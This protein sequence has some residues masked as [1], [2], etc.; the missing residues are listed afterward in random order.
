MLFSPWVV[1][2]AAAVPLACA[3]SATDTGGFAPMNDGGAA[4]D[5]APGDD[6]GTHADAASPS[7]D[8]ATAGEEGG[9]GAGHDGG[10]SSGGGDSSTTGSDSGTGGDSA[11]GGDSSTSGGDSGGTPP[12]DA[13]PDAPSITTPWDISWCPGAQIT[14]SQVLAFFQPATTSATLGAATLDARQRACQD[15]TGCQA[16][17]TATSV[18]LYDVDWN[19]NGFDFPSAATVD[20][21]AHGTITCTVPGPSCTASIG[22]VT[23]GV[24]PPS[25]GS[26]LWSVS[27]DVNGSQ[28]QVGN[29]SSDPSGDYVTWGQTTTTATCLWGIED[30]RVYSTGGQYTEYQMVIFASY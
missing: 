22:V 26:F 11:T 30:G 25:Q 24:Y 21:P 3:S 23:S 14:Q 8:G 13:G 15:Q 7:R 6:G 4:S 27:P 18:P 12:P 2:A 29:W 9:P 10:S 5:A 17:T 16:W 28:A 20:V 1:C 19:G